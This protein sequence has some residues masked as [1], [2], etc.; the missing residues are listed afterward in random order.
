MLF[1]A[2]LKHL[3]QPLSQVPL[4]SGLSSG[5]VAALGSFPQLDLTTNQIH[6]ASGRAALC[7]S[8]LGPL[9]SQLVPG[10]LLHGC[11]S[12]LPVIQACGTPGFSSQRCPLGTCHSNS[13]HSKKGPVSLGPSLNL[14]SLFS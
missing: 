1:Q 5:Q 14:E 7:L 6:L 10:P 9:N 8:F 4:D 12:D 13:V 11:L 2:P 3:T